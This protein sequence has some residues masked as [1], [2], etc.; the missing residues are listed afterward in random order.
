MVFSRKSMVEPQV[1]DLSDAGARR[2][3]NALAH[4]RRR[5]G[6]RDRSGAGLEHVMA[7]RAQLE[8]VLVNLVLNARDA[9]PDGG[10]SPRHRQPEFARRTAWAPRT[11][12]RPDSTSC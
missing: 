12:C 9:M 1:M 7:D 6:H 4:H 3:R 2:R 11:R 8:Q 5:R 10:A